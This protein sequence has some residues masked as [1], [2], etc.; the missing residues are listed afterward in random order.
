M[1][2]GYMVRKR[3]GTTALRHDLLVSS[4]SVELGAE[5]EANVDVGARAGA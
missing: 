3:L 1:L 4:R 2:K 5:S